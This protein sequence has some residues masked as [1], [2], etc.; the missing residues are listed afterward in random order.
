[1][2]SLT[3]LVIQLILS[4]AGCYVG[5]YGIQYKNLDKAWPIPVMWGLLALSYILFGMI[6]TRWME[7]M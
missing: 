1:M 2:N 3:L 6:A 7:G 5:W 4:V